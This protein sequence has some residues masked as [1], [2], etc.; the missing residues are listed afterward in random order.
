MTLRFS[1][2]GLGAYAAVCM[3]AGSSSADDIYSLPI[4]LSP[5]VINLRCSAYA[6]GD[7]PWTDALSYRINLNDSTVNGEKLQIDRIDVSNPKLSENLLIDPIAKG[8]KLRWHRPA[9]A[10]V[11]AAYYSLDLSHGRL[12]VISEYDGQIAFQ[13]RCTILKLKLAV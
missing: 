6:G 2:L 13:F 8:P 11:P 12:D 10:S 4:T 1:V 5:N 3:S 7:G 9:N